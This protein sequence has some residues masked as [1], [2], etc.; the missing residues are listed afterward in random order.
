MQYI[1]APVMFTDTTDHPMNR[2][3]TPLAAALYGPT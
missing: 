1:I 2:S 3:G